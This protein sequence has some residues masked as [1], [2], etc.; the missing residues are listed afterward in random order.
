[1]AVKLTFSRLLQQ[2]IPSEERGGEDADNTDKRPSKGVSRPP[3]SLPVMTNNFRRFNARWDSA[4]T[5]YTF[6][7]AHYI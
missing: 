1:M 7:V 6:L 2:V 5:F 3:F 4:Y